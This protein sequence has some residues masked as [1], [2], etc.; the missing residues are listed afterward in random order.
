MRLELALLTLSGH[1]MFDSLFFW[2]RLEGIE[3][4]YY[5]AM[6]V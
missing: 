4:D 2:G 6:G 1:Y 5:I 3:R